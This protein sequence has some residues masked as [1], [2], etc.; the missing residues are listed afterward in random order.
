MSVARSASWV[1]RLTVLVFLGLRPATAVVI[2]S[3]D[4]SGNTSAPADDPGWS[5]VGAIGGHTTGVYLGNHW[6][7][8]AR[9]AGLGELQLG[10]RLYQAVQGKI[11]HRI[12]TGSA[13]DSELQ[14]F[15]LRERPDLPAP[16]LASSAPRVDTP[17]V[18]IG[19]GLNRS[20][21]L[22]GWSLAWAIVPRSEASYTGYQAG[23]GRTM[24]WGTNRIAAVD[25]LVR[26]GNRVSVSFS[27]QFDAGRP[28]P[29]EAQASNGDS[30]GPVFA[31][32]GDGNWELIGIMTTISQH[33]GQPKNLSIYG[34]ATYAVDIHAY[35]DQIERIIASSPDQDGDGILD[36]DDNCTRVANPDQSDNDGDGTGDVCDEPEGA[37]GSVPESKAGK[38]PA[39]Q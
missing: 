33:K 10:D 17:V 16:R 3:G 25:L 8:T 5:N 18:I 15:Q 4:G 34:D 35:R 38:E 31:K 12:F 11:R 30:G 22:A 9:H 32:N 24:R 1:L 19:N 26:T 2:D 27:T 28:T 13:L 29:H 20:P 39:R 7:L 14:L 23:P 36:V 21:S 6:V 37:E